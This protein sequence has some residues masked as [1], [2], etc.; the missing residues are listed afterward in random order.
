MRRSKAYLDATGTETLI[1]L[2]PH[3]VRYPAGP[4][5]GHA[6]PGEPRGMPGQNP[7]HAPGR[8]AGYAPLRSDRLGALELDWRAMRGGSEGGDRGA[9]EKGSLRR[10]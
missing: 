2:N 6:P 9:G 10:N 5:P 8:D 7:R 4:S 1:D 3:A